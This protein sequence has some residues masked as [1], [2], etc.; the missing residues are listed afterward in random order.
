MGAARV[1]AAAA[2][3]YARAVRTVAGSLPGG[4]ERD[5][6]DLFDTLQREAYRDGG[7]RAVLRCW[8]SE[9]AALVRLRSLG[10]PRGP[11]LSSWRYDIRDA[12]RTLRHTP[13]YAAMVVVML[14]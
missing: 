13:G 4:S 1:F 3:I 2:A 9:A 6:V 11:V 8:T 7:W 10:P 12:W 5:A 14:A